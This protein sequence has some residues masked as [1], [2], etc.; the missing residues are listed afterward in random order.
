MKKKYLYSNGDSWTYG[1]EIGLDDMQQHLNEKYYN[2]WPWFLSQELDIPIC[3]NEAAGAGSNDRIYRKT[4]Q[5]IKEYINKG[6]NPKELMIVIGWTTPERTE[7]GMS[8]NDDDV[9]YVRITAHSVLNTSNNLSK[10]VMGDIE[11]YRNY[12]LNLYSENSGIQKQLMYMDNLRFLCKELDIDYYDFIAI[13]YWPP[14]IVNK[15]RNL[16]IKLKNFYSN[17]SFNNSVVSNNWDTYPLKHPTPETH[18]KW[19]NVL[20]KFIV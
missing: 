1:E 11:K 15:A 13:G 5:F 17:D 2:S 6:K 12:F 18:K 19:A 16:K 9:E 20:K 3:I 14:K 7:V 8:V 10:M 4:Y